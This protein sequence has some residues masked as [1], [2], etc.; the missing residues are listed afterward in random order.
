MTTNG[1]DAAVTHED[2]AAI[3]ALF[4]EFLDGWNDGSGERYAAPFTDPCDF[5]AFDGTHLTS[6]QQIATVHQELF[7]KWLRGTR[8]T[9]Q[10]NVR[11]L[12][13]HAALVVARGDTIMRGKTRP[14]PDLTPRRF[15]P[16]TS[17]GRRLAQQGAYLFGVSRL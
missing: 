15:R 17:G 11:F 7:D 13:P 9:G 8:P 12:G 2:E 16:L 6:T 10:P 5:I 1:T 4:Q 3:Q 14:A